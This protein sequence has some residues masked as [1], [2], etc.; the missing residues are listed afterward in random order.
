MKKPN[1]LFLMSDQQRHDAL[2]CV[3][4]VVQTPHLD[5]LASQGIRF[6]QAT[7]QAPICVPSRYSMMLGLYPSQSGLRFNRQ[8]V[9]SDDKLPLS[10]IPQYFQNAGYQTAGFGKTHW[11]EGTLNIPGEETKPSLRGFEE[12]GLCFPKNLFSAEKD[13]INMFDEHGGKVASIEE[14]KSGGPGGETVKGYEG[15]TSSYSDEEHREGWAAQKAIDFLQNNRDHERPFFLYLSLD[16]PHPPFFVPPGYESRYDIDDIPDQKVADDFDTLSEHW[17]FPN[18]NIQEAWAQKSPHERRLTTLR[19]YAL[20]TYVDTLFGKVLTQLEAMGELEN[21]LIVYCSDHGD[22]LG[23][24]NHRFSKYCLYEGSMRVPLILAGAGIPESLRGTVDNQPA[25]L[26]DILPTLLNMIEEPVP[27]ELPGVSLV[28]SQR[29]SGSLCEF[30]GSGYEKV[31]HGPAYAWRT[32][33]WKL[34]LHLDMQARDAISRTDE[35]Q[36]ELY[37]LTDDPLEL[38]NLYESDE[39]LKIREQLTREL[40]MNV[41]VNQARYPRQTTPVS[42]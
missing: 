31:Q 17:S 33:E 35:A 13:A 9:P 34:I 38:N 3:N 12:R 27:P 36:G 42:F 24:R 23:E 15:K 14:I 39:Y 5:E 28:G 29:K 4:P 1:V 41:M 6:A 16:F 25:E 40:L 2:G 37:H 7:C 22:M 10:V 11:Y 19:Y 18:Q 32:P 8:I 26:V 20:C 30:H 21:T